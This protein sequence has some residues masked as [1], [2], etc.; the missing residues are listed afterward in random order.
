M[1]IIHTLNINH[2]AVKKKKKKVHNKFKAVLEQK[3]I[4]TGHQYINYSVNWL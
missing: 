1:C 4:T 3:L 2:S